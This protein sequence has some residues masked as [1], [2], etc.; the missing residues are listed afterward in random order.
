MWPA[1]RA[2]LRAALGAALATALVDRATHAQEAEVIE[3]PELA[4]APTARQEPTAPPASFRLELHSRTAIDTAWQNAR[5]EVIESTQIARFEAV[6]YRS[7]D[8]RFDVGLRA[9]HYFARREADTAEGDAERYELDVVPLA[10]YADATL[11]DGIHLRAGYQTIW[12][13]RFDF[14]SATN[15]LAVLDLRNGL[16]TMPEALEFA[17]PAARLDVDLSSELTLEAVYVPFFQPHLVTIAGSDY[18]LLAFLDQT[19]PT[20]VSGS[21]AIVRAVERSQIPGVTTS[22]VQALDPQP[23]LEHPQ[24]ALRFS[25]RPRGGE[26]GLT[27]GT[28]LERLPAFELSAELH[29]VLEGP[30]LA[31]FIQ[32][33]DNL[34][35]QVALRDALVPLAAV[36][37]PFR[38]SYGRFFVYSVDG[39]LD[40]SPVQLGFEAAY[41]QN[42][43]FNASR[44]GRLP[45]PGTSDVGHFA[46]RAELVEPVLVASTEAFVASAFDEP[47]DPARSWMLLDKGHWLRG[48]AA[49]AR[50]TPSGIPFAFEL[51]G[52]I[53]TGK[54]LFLS[55]RVEWQASDGLYF[56][57]GA[58]FLEGPKPG[59]LGEP[60]LSIGGIYDGIDQVF[61]GVRWIP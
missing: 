61:V 29:D 3:D 9:R 26:I 53:A 46:L 60:D 54:T 31:A 57:L 32:D 8:L 43:V 58:H 28:A 1:L 18:A 7:E 45:I 48:L 59:A 37:K 42:R 23:S 20:S 13:G 52:L 40:L 51:L 27:V 39:A 34:G 15:F 6:Y 2:P 35:N 21:P 25:A 19:E 12:L 14:W 38:V 44:P 16:T 5:E 10:A 49:A 33:P 41:L 17:Q 56:E 11:S 55:P 47:S 36:E 50:L 24:G 4:R 30:E 22:G